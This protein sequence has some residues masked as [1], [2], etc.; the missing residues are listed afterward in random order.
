MIKER[1]HFDAGRG[2]VD[3]VNQDQGP[4]LVLAQPRSRNPGWAVTGS[5]GYYA[6]GA[7]A[8]S[9]GTI[10][11]CYVLS[12]KAIGAQAEDTTC[13]MLTLDDAGRKKAY[14]LN[15]DD[16]SDECW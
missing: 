11:S 9:C 4:A 8:G 15:G 2:R 10:A 7:S 6:L 14:T 1:L 12:A 5:N 13:Y 16:S 3:T